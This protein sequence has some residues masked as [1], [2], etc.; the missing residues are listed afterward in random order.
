ML[1]TLAAAVGIPAGPLALLLAMLAGYPLALGWRA[2]PE[3]PTVKHV[4]SYL[5]GLAIVYLGYGGEALLHSMITILVTWAM[6]K[7]LPPN[8]SLPLGWVF[9]VAYLL[10]G[11][12]YYMDSEGYT[13][14]WTTQQ[15]VLTLRLVGM[16]FD[17]SDG[18][19]PEESMDKDAKARHLKEVPGL[20]ET[21]S[22]SYHFG[23]V[24][25]GPQFPFRLY[26]AFVKGKLLPEKRP[27]AG[28]ATLQ[29]FAGGALYLGLSEVFSMYYPASVVLTKEYLYSRPFFWRFLDIVLCSRGFMYKYLGIWKLGEAPNVLTGLSYNGVDSDGE[30]RWDGVTN[31]YL[32]GYETATR[33]QTIVETFNVNTNMWMKVYVMKRL[34]FL[35]NK[36]ASQ[37]GALMFLA[38]WHG[39]YPGY[40]LSFAMEFVDMM[41]ER[42]L[43]SFTQPYT[44]HWYGPTA[45]AVQKALGVAYSAFTWALTLVALA[46]GAIPFIQ[47]TFSRMI[48]VFNSMYWLS[49]VPYALFFLFVFLRPRRRKGKAA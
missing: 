23:G 24:L 17:V 40:F 8:L 36:T 41:I 12:Y 34:R 1:D 19:L 33:L 9:N 28:F 14:N 44:R 26:D 21:L 10:V 18:R 39:P 2:L 7:V 4:Y 46:I 32:L 22:F 31:I 20:L 37:L 15:C 38:L 5:S 3:D 13:L 48:I 6:L 47:L 49:H 35:G 25:V 29:C 43:V 45:S 11:C 27:P 16:C 30:P 42:E